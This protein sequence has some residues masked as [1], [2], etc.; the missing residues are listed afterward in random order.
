VDVGEDGGFSTNPDTEQRVSARSATSALFKPRS[1]SHV[2]RLLPLEDVAVD[3][4]EQ[5]FVRSW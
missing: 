2:C 5:W 4:D 3:E 1:R